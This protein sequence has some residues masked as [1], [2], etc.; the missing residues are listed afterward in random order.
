MTSLETML[1]SDNEY[2][3]PAIIVGLDNTLGN[4]NH[5]LHYIKDEFK[6]WDHYHSSC[7]KDELNEWCYKLIMYMRMSGVHVIFI[8]DRP[9]DQLTKTLLWME[10]HD[11]NMEDD[12][13][14]LHMREIGDERS[15]AKVKFDL[16][17][18]H[19]A[20]DYDILYAIDSNK[21]VE[22]IYSRMGVTTLL[23][24]PKKRTTL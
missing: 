8:T 14:H 4:C 13:I 16:F 23:F 15:P 10:E 20:G 12:H 1:S 7:D 24:N 2:Y 5:R 19:V 11:I 18:E 22:Q 21:L 3:E 9:Y 6:H 17:R